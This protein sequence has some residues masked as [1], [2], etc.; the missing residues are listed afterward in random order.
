[1]TAR[2]NLRT[3]ILA[4]IN[5]ADNQATP[6]EAAGVMADIALTFADALRGEP[7]V[8]GV[9]AGGMASIL[10]ELREQNQMLRKLMSTMEMVGIPVNVREPGSSS[11]HGL[12][13]VVGSNSPV[14]HDAPAYDPR[15]GTTRPA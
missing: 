3:A 9:V 14:L 2:D 13:F 12:Q 4:A 7:V 15:T 8:A 11:T 1:M 5:A 6:E 10:A